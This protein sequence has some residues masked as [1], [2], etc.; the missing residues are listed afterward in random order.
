[1]QGCREVGEVGKESGGAGP[2]SPCCQPALYL[3]CGLLSGL[4]QVRG[5]GAWAWPAL[6]DGDL[7][8]GQAGWSPT[9]ACVPGC[10]EE[11]SAMRGAG[12]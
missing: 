12:L 5:P 10:S 6:C 11:R 8:P 1:M 7:G 9:T 3:L 2:R 4:R